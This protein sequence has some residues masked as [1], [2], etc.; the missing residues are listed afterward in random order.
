MTI[1]VGLNIIIRNCNIKGAE[2][3]ILCSEINFELPVSL[4]VYIYYDPNPKPKPPNP[5]NPKPSNP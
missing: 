2:A 4:C 5:R 1:A 3:A